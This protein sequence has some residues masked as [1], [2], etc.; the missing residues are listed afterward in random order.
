MAAADG[1]LDFADRVPRLRVDGHV[2]AEFTR[3]RQFLVGDVHRRDVQPHRLGVLHGEVSEAADARDDH[4][5]PRTSVGLFK[6]LVGRHTGAKDGRRLD[7]AETVGQ[8]RDVGRR[9]EYVLG[10]SAVHRVAGVL[11]KGAE[12]LPTR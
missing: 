8:A 2:R 9:R 10:E 1:L 3:Q 11:L 12:R 7:K 5:L 6:P 4:P